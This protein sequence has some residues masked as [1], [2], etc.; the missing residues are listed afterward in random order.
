MLTY[1]LAII[2]AGWAGF[3]AALKGRDLGFKT[4]LIDSGPIG[5]TCLNRGC[6]PTKSLISCAKVFSLAK[7]ASDFGVRLD[8]PGMDFSV[9]QQRKSR[10]IARLAQGMR[11]RLSG[12]DFFNSPATL[13]AP[14]EIRIAK[15]LIKSR[16]ILLAT[17][18]RPFSLPGFEFDG[19]KII[20]SDDI[21]ESA[22][23]PSS[24]LIIGGGVIGCEFA[25]LFS[26]LGS[27]V[28]LAEKMPLLL[29]AEDRDIS[30][31][32]E[33]V[34]G[35][36]GIKVIT[37]ADLSGIKREEYDKILVCAGR[38]P[39][40]EGLNL[41]E[42][43]VKFE[44]G[45]LSSDENLNVGLEGVY[46]AG[47]CVS[48][49]MLAHYAAYQGVRAVENMFSGKAKNTDAPAVP[50]CIFTDPQIGS[51]GMKE[52]EALDA[53]LKIKVYKSDFRANA[54]SHILDET[55]GFVKIIARD[56]GRI[57][58]AS[59]VG[60]QASELIAVLTAAVSFESTVSKLRS[61]IFA[62]PTLSESLHEALG[63]D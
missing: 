17:G 58:G 28:T 4:C 25:G 12:I 43:G 41:P 49:I 21:L 45:R 27:K 55:E 42:A 6:I 8:N 61:V 54:M 53:G 1:D 34:F 57:I 32:I 62:H 51:V 35:K 14:H 16:F 30:R 37:G 44:N 20:S 50:A 38:V 22:E 2:G 9:I 26:A 3:N 63:S 10:I 59:I 48:R 33:A 60:P 31:K 52:K 11:G 19:K 13:H 7:K 36:R 5:G 24:L 18:S 56:D 29:P 15:D 46:A 39:N 47:D 40:L 23:A